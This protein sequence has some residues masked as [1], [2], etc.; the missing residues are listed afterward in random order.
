MK[1]LGYPFSES[2]LS[3]LNLMIQ[4]QQ[5]AVQQAGGSNETSSKQ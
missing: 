1:E 4:A 2:V 3:T 5:Q